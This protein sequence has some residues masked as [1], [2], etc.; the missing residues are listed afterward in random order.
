[1]TTDFRRAQASVEAIEQLVADLVTSE[2]HEGFLFY[3]RLRSEA[4][5]L[6]D[7][8]VVIGS[9]SAIEVRISPQQRT[10][11]AEVET[12]FTELEPLVDRL[13]RRC[14]AR[15]DFEAVKDLLR[16]RLEAA[17]VRTSPEGSNHDSLQLLEDAKSFVE[18]RCV[19]YEE[20]QTL[21]AKMMELEA[22]ATYGTKMVEQVL[23]LIARHDA[24]YALYNTDVV[25]RL[26]AAVIAA[27]ANEK[28]RRMATERQ[29]SAEA[30]EEAQ[31]QQ[32][33]AWRP[34]AAL[35]AASEQCQQAR[36]EEEDC[37]EWQCAQS[38]EERLR[39]FPSDCWQEAAALLPTVL[40]MYS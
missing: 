35:L 40:W 4:V 19:G 13:R 34:V 21:L 31:R 30:E 16:Q 6:E 24:A 12:R 39:P 25:P 38:L 29:L 15:E 22:S 20:V 32:M 1:M 7:D 37:A 11:F 2:S 27:S 28:L 17:G 26:G 8:W 14:I 36:Q 3:P 10:K 5:A 9:R 18:S 33:E 23:D